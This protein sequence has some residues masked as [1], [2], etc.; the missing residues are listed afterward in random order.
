MGAIKAIDY[1][2]AAK[3]DIIS[4]SWGAKIQASQATPL[5][6]A[7]G[8]A[9]DA[10]VMFIAAATNDGANNDVT[11]MYPANA[12]FQNMIAVAASDNSDGK[13]SWSNYGKARVALAS[14]GLDILS[15]LPNN[16]YGNLSGTSMATPMVAGLAALLQSNAVQTTGKGLTGA[17]MRSLL[18][19]TGAKVAIE[20]ACDCRIDATA[21]IEA[22]EANTMVVVP[23]AATFA[24]NSTGK[25]NAI[26]G[27]GGY[28]FTSMAPATLEV[29]ADGTFTAKVEGETTVKVTDSN[30]GTAQSLTIRV[31]NAPAGGG[32]ACPIQDPNLC[33]LLC[34]F[35]PSLP[36]CSK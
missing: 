22:L 14:P 34:L 18:Q 11:S 6:E 27:N 8:R 5:I 16:T 17:E 2:I 15:S 10:G 19:T 36:W 1:A 30:G 33:M 21:A 13:P 32:E 20:T 26:G 7:I 24:P 25:F 28:Q 23:A 35:D 31:A 9:N 3:S 4:A 12:E 29:A